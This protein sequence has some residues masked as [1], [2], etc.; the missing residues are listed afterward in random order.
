MRCPFCGDEE[1]RV[2]DT[3]LA[4]D[5]EEIR[6][7]RECEECERRFTTRE[8]IEQAIPKIIKRDERREEY[9][10]D[11]L[12][13]SIERACVKRPISADAVERLIDRIERRLQEGGDKEVSSRYIGERV[14][15][16]LTA[17]DALAAVRFASVFRS[18][19]ST[20]DYAAFFAALSAEEES[21]PSA[22][23][24]DEGQSD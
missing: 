13:R 22:R 11:K 18:F 4:R 9:V 17:I 2:I 12:A 5:G 15:D 10:R 19:D 7:R 24:E 21:E 1:N 20:E 8:R 3:R 23:E 16:E 6:R 14:M